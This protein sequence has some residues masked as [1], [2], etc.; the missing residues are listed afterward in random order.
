MSSTSKKT[1][2]LKR[3]PVTKA[4][5]KPISWNWKSAWKWRPRVSQP[6]QAYQ[7]TGAATAAVSA[8][9]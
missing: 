5:F 2:R 9:M 3:S 4:P 1:K 7:S 8:S 6:P